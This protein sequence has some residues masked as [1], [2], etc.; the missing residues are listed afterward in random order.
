[1]TGLFFCLLVSELSETTDRKKTNNH[2]TTE[3][4]PAMNET[5]LTYALYLALA[6][7]MTVWVARTLHR[8]GRVFLVECFHGSA[9]L[10]DSVNHLL[11]VGFYL[12]NIGFVSLYLKTT[13][14]VAGARGVFEALSGKM[15]IV[16]L[17][18]G[19]MHFFNLLVFARMRKRGLLATLPPPV[20]PMM[21]VEAR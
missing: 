17:V 15:G 18:L 6:I 8:S 19:G 12:I 7:S 2:N 10:A 11:V 9:E 20:A 16:L 1:M 3:R 4:K 5:V 13:E 21:K 14:E